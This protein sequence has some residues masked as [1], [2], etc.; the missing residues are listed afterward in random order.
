V[1]AEVRN[2][3]PQSPRL[4]KCQT[5]TSA[6][7][8]FEQFQTTNGFKAASQ[9]W[10]TP[11]RPTQ[12][13]NKVY[14][15]TV[16]LARKEVCGMRR[17]WLSITLGFWLVFPLVTH[18]QLISAKEIYVDHG[19]QAD[20]SNPP[21]KNVREDVMERWV[22]GLQRGEFNLP[23]MDKLIGNWLEKGP[24]KSLS[25]AIAGTG[26]Q[27]G[28]MFQP[29]RYANCGSLVIQL[30]PGTTNISVKAYAAGQD[31]AQREGRFLICNVG[32]SAWETWQDG[33]YIAAV[34]KNWSHN[35]ARTARIEVYGSV[36]PKKYTVV[37]G[38]CLSRIAQA[39]YGK[40]DWPKI[41]RANKRGISDP[42]L[43]YPAQELMLP[44]P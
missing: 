2:R 33:E 41:Y 40:Q 9:T 30:P 8:Q 39:I 23:S 16:S 24:A 5:T 43:I 4:T 26:G 14:N 11:L 34:F 10:H 35:L 6:A 25:D 36:W 38:D 31:C 29:N 42:D 32:W 15:V 13:R 18:S 7:L 20:V 3:S 28:H 17:V 1:Y 37:K 21:C 12:S 27:L 44:A 22:T 19:D